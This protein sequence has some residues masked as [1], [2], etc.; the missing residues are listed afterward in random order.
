DAVGGEPA[1][2]ATAEPLA[3]GPDELFVLGDHGVDSRDGRDFGPVPQDAVL[4]TPE[5]VVWPLHRARW[6][7]R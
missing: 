7:R 2:Y 1:R 5:L 4:G 6:L 3:L